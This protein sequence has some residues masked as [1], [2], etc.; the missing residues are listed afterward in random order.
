MAGFQPKA[1][2]F[3]VGF[4]VFMFPLPSAVTIPITSHLKVFSAHLSTILLNIL[5][6]QAIWQGN[7]IQLPHG[8]MVVNDACSGIRAIISLLAMATVLAYWMRTSMTKKLLLLLAVVPIALFV[9]ASRI[10][11]LSIITEF[12][13]AQ[14]TLGWLHNC[15]GLLLFGFAFLFLLGI[16]NVLAAGKIIL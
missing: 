7:I 15:A 16:K 3:P 1:L 14:Y 12:W 6:L 10:A 9:N 8:T 13:G 11:F 2:L 5:Q 4:L